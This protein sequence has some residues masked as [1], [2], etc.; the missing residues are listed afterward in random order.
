MCVNTFE[1]CLDITLRHEGGFI[2]HPADKG[3]PTN[4]GIT[5]KVLADWRGN[6]ATPDDVRYLELSEV[7]EIYKARYW[8]P[9]KAELLPEGLDLCAFDMAVNHGVGRAVRLMQEAVGVARDGV[10]GPK[11][12]KAL[13]AMLLPQLIRLVCHERREFYQS[14]VRHNQSQKVFLNG[15]MNRADDIEKK[16]ILMATK[17]LHP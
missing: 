17:E 15:W 11:T 12:L 3:G 7:R 5:L 8:K 1:Q 9:V 4:R 2:W 13:Q 14:I 6:P 16:A 10:L